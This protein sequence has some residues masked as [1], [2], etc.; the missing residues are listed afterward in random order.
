MDSRLREVKRKTK[1]IGGKGKG[2]LTDELIKDLTLYYGLA[3]RRHPDLAE[4]MKK[5][6]WATFLHKCSKDDKLMHEYCP[7]G[8]NSWCKWRVAEAKGQLNDFHHEPALHLFK[9]PFDR[10]MRL[11]RV[12]IY[13]KGALAE[14][15]KTTMKVLTPAFGN[16]LLN[17]FTVVYK[18]LK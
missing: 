14:T 18:Q 5:A 3:I 17:T 2:K 6:V 15:H 13:Y 12:T 7:R 10:C 1:G 8:E 11:F 9:K 16:L 4:E